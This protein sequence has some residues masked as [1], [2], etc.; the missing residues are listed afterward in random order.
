ME[1]TDKS[2][3]T[4]SQ[5]EV[6][7]K[8]RARVLPLVMRMRGDI[9]QVFSRYVGPISSELGA[10]EFDRWREEGHVG[11]S[12]LHRYITRLARHISDDAQ[13]REFMRFASRCI[14]VGAAK[15]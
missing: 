8:R 2:G 12:G 15:G 4:D 10:E 6:P 9:D 13:R 11:P 1:A 14:H 3:V 7:N 5:S